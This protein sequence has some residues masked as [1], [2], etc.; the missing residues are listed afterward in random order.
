MARSCFFDT[1]Y[2]I[3]SHFNYILVVAI[4]PFRLRRTP[5][6]RSARGELSPF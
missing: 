2:D 4:T 1:R 6:A 5:P 3:L